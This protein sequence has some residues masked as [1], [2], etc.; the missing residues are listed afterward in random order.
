M[1]EAKSVEPVPE[2]REALLERV[3]AHLASVTTEQIAG[4]VRLFDLRAIVD[5]RVP[6]NPDEENRR[7]HVLL[8]DLVAVSALPFELLL[9]LGELADA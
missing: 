1:G 5:V 9:G 2:D 4:M 3:A 8:V 7:A 6:N